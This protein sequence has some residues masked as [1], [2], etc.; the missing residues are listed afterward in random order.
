M[1]RKREDI[2]VKTYPRPGHRRIQYAGTNEWIVVPGN[3]PAEARAFAEK[4]KAYLLGT[5]LGED[6]L[7]SFAKDFY[8]PQGE[9]ATYTQ[10]KGRRPYGGYY[11]R[12]A[13]LLHYYVLPQFGSMSMHALDSLTI[14]KWVGGLQSVRKGTPLAAD[15]KNQILTTIRHIYDYAKYKG[16]VD[17]NPVDY[18][19]P[20]HGHKSRP[21][22]LPEEIERMFP[23][24]EAE[25]RRIWPNLTWLCF[26][27][28]LRD[29]GLRTGEAL[30]LDWHN[31]SAT[32][33]CFAIVQKFESSTGRVLPGT[34]TGVTRAVV[35]SKRTAGYL[36]QL[37]KEQAKETGLI[38][39]GDGKKPYCENN[40]CDRLKDALERAGI[41]RFVD[42][43]GRTPYSFRH[44]FVTNMLSTSLD[45]REVAL[46]AGHSP[47]M[48]ANYN[49]PTNDHLFKR[50]NHLRDQ[51]EKLYQ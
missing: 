30:A 4:N 42:G 10:A 43:Q 36:A 7:G 19:K 24:D 49:H 17:R 38:F 23:W 25:L 51:V 18:I 48:Q 15:T 28:I 3:T 8:N 45:A 22:F 40:V 50:I 27:L 39:T 37:Y 41:P 31:Y 46:L 16:I 20:Y 44:A 1:A 33:Q 6:L 9:W 47:Q 13:G 5:R 29:T 2:L 14:D 26:Y 35:V 12:L 34:K 21:A 11:R 32:Y